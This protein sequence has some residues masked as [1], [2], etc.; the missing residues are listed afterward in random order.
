MHRAGA[1][2]KQQGSRER[3]GARGRGKSEEQHRGIHDG[4]TERQEGDFYNVFKLFET[5]FTILKCEIL[6]TCK[7]TGTYLAFSL[8]FDY[9]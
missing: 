2:G 4:H 9:F 5:Y 7:Y 1:T 8:I 3:R 6:N